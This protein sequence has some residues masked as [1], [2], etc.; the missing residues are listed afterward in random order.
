MDT[1]NSANCSH[2]M[3]KWAGFWDGK[4]KISGEPT[5][6]PKAICKE[7]GQE[8]F[9]TWP[10]WEKIPEQNREGSDKIKKMNDWA[11]SQQ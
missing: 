4:D 5:G 1:K 8:L 7:C 11:Q 10:E 3:V 2:L 6:G 9:L